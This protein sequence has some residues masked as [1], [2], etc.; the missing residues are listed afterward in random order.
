MNLSRPSAS[1]LISA[2]KLL[3]LPSGINNMQQLSLFLKRLLLGLL[4]LPSKLTTTGRIEFRRISA[5]SSYCTS[6]YVDGDDINR[7]RSG[8]K[9]LWLM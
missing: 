2:F 1:P 6:R 4:I 5:I 8:A 7:D 9:Y 3:I